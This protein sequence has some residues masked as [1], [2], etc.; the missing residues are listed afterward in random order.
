MPKPAKKIT[1]VKVVYEG[2]E[3]R[4]DNRK[5]V[6]RKNPAKYTGK[7]LDKRFAGRRDIHKRLLIES[8]DVGRT[9]PKGQWPALKEFLSKHEYPLAKRFENKETGVSGIVF[10]KDGKQYI[11]SSR[12]GLVERRQPRYE[13]RSS[14]NKRILESEKSS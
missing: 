1:V 14:R 6:R 13:K 3:R 8:K 11:K 10:S 4:T 7:L 12:R 2:L 5:G 9:I